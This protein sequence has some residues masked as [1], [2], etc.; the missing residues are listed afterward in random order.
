[1][2]RC[3]AERF[4]SMYHVHVDTVSEEEVAEVSAVRVEVIGLQGGKGLQDEEGGV[5][6]AL[7]Y[8]AQT[9]VHSICKKILYSENPT[10]F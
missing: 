10:M 5:L 2:W 3:A 6:Q 8:Q 4:V 9:Q 1:M 7:S